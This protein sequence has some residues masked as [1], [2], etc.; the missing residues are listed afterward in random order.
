VEERDGS[1]LLLTTGRHIGEEEGEG[2]YA[3][4]KAVAKG[5]GFPIGG[6]GLFSPGKR[7]LYLRYLFVQEL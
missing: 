6:D 2:P 4:A 1:P 5:K 3:E 7:I